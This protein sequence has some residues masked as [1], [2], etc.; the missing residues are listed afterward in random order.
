MS[1]A[2]LVF[3]FTIFH[4]SNSLS[5]TRMMTR[6]DRLDA[7]VIDSTWWKN[8]RKACLMPDMRWPVRTIP[9]CWQHWRKPLQRV[10][11]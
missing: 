5:L 3:H 11:L 10:M 4:S 7:V 9:S 2:S 1:E 6:T 8:S